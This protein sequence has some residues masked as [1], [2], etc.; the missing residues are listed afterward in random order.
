M[1]SDLKRP[2][3]LDCLYLQRVRQKK[4]SLRYLDIAQIALEMPARKDA[5]VCGKREVSH[6]CSRLQWCSNTHIR[7]L[8][9]VPD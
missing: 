7:S 1:R 2:G 9:Y 3:L 5:A 8:V 6:L 4:A